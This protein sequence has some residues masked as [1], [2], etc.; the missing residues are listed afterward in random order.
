MK[1]KIHVTLKNGV[2]DPQGQAIGHALESLGF[3]G[4]G[5]VRQG[6]YI[7]IDLVG[8][9]KAVA[10]RKKLLPCAANSSPTPL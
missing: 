4:V 7:E 9:A 3:D 5:D 10:Q 6:K 8:S 2:H 1:A